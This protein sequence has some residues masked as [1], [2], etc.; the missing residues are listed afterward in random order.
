LQT[1]VKFEHLNVLR[2]TEPCNPTQHSP[3]SQVSRC[4]TGQEISCILSKPEVHYHINNSPPLAYV[5]YEINQGPALPFHFFEIHFHIALLS[6]PRSSKWSL[7][8]RSSH[9]N[10]VSLSLLFHT[11]Y[12]SHSFLPF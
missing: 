8:Y 12:I 5:L 9:Q 3:D 6:T 2:D 11:C 7:S 4:A 1:K 10:P